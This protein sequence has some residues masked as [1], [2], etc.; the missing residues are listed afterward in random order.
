MN[1]P[2]FKQHSSPD[3]CHL[4]AEKFAPYDE[5]FLAIHVFPSGR[6]VG[7]ETSKKGYGPTAPYSIPVAEFPGSVPSFPRR[8]R[9]KLIPIASVRL[10]PESGCL[11]LAAAFEAFP[12]PERRP[13]RITRRIVRD[14]AGNFT[15]LAHLIV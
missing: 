7:F 11:L 5:D 14:G 12:T 13:T 3:H 4:G 2:R 9:A 15:L 6:P 1:V 10:K 8:Y